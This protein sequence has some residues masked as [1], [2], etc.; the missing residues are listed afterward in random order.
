[1]GDCYVTN[2]QS[3][4]PGQL[5][6]VKEFYCEKNASSSAGCYLSSTKEDEFWHSAKILVKVKWGTK[7]YEK[8][9]LA[10]EK[11]N[12]VQRKSYDE[13]TL[14]TFVYFLTKGGLKTGH[15]EDQN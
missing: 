1:M 3:K 7:I 15:W 4:G 5:H 14:K 9:K 11:W 8:S 13:W 6:Y 12:G 10:L 2:Q